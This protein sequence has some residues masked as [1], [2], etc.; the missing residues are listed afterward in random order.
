MEKKVCKFINVGVEYLKTSDDFY[1]D[2]VYII[3]DTESGVL[4]LCN[5]DHGCIVSMTPWLK[6]DG[7]PHMDKI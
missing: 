5:Y 6:S 4:Y 2:A 3:K 1:P 7:S